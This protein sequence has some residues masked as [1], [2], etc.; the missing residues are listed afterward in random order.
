[1]L[2][3]LAGAIGGR[4]AAKELKEKALQEAIGRL[5]DAV[6]QYGKAYVTGLRIK[7]E[8]L[9]QTAR[10]LELPFRLINWMAPTPGDVV[11]RDAIRAYR[12]WAR[13]CRATAEE[14]IKPGGTFDGIGTAYQ[15]AGEIALSQGGLEPVYSPDIARCF[16]LVRSA[17]ERAMSERKKLGYS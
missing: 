11:R 12:R 2:G 16:G 10:H 8:S 3:G 14:L 4:W 1:V 17:L 7:A 5:E 15:S 6:E 13:S 9:E